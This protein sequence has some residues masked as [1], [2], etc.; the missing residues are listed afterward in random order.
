MAVIPVLGL[1]NVF[2][3]RQ[4]TLHV[5]NAL[6]SIEIDSPSHVRSGLIFTTQVVIT[7]HLPVRKCELTLGQGWFSGMTLNGI[8][9]QP[10]QQTANGNWQVWQFGALKADT[11]FRV[12]ISWQTN[13]TSIG[14]RSQPLAVLDGNKQLATANRSLTIFP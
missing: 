5:S 13:P 7:P 8:T 2:G 10:S 4:Q 14:R 12:W 9:P 1:F 6:A 3:Q 11:P